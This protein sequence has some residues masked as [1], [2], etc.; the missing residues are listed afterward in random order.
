MNSA[1]QDNN[2]G[3]MR[4]WRR[5][6]RNRLLDVS[7]GLLSLL[8]VV[9]LAGRLP[10]RAVHDDYAQYHLSSRLVMEG[11]NPYT[12]AFG[13]MSVGGGVVFRPDI[14]SATN[15]PGLLWLFAPFVLL[16]VRG[17]FWVWVAMEAASLAV[18]L[19][20]TRVL[21]RDR[22]SRRGWWFVCAAA[23][24]SSAVFWNFHF[25]QVQ[26]LLAA[27]VLTAFHLRQTGRS[28]AACVVAAIAGAM[29]LY[30]L[31]LLPWFVWGS[32]GDG[33]K[34]WRRL[35]WATGSSGLL[36]LVTGPA[37]WQG[38]VESG[39]P[40]LQRCAIGPTYFNFTV[41]SLASNL[42]ALAGNARAGWLA[43]AVASVA[44]WVLIYAVCWRG[45]PDAAAQFSLLC[46]GMLACGVTTWGHYLVFLIFPLAWLAMQVARRPSPGGVVLCGLLF[47]TLNDL[48]TWAGPVLDRHIHLKILVNFVPLYGMLALGGWLVAKLWRRS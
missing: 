23:V 7:V 8:C 47:L 41:T 42:G 36:V 43:G 39:M 3:T 46:V 40:I 6:A 32:D 25:S 20:L 45:L 21:L 37:L 27:L 28:T 9:R 30:P 33:A 26:L 31:V 16:P 24:S 5:L 29:K 18:I 2:A 22:L 19:W 48:D 1:A 38:F 15:P 4:W 35:A 34:R 10:D 17:A 13:P 12:T 44:L 14:P 11:R